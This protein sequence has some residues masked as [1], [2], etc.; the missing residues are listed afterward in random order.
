MK[1]RDLE[2]HAERLARQELAAEREAA[3]RR[4]PRGRFALAAIALSAVLFV[5][6][7]LTP[8]AEEPATPEPPL[9]AWKHVR[10]TG[11]FIRAFAHTGS[12]AIAVG[13][14]GA[15]LVSDEALET[16]DRLELVIPEDAGPYANDPLLAAGPVRE[17]LS[18]IAVLGGGVC[19]LVGGLEDSPSSTIIRTSDGGKTWS[20][21]FGGEM[22]W[23]QALR[24]DEAFGCAVGALGAC[25]TTS[26]GGA[27]WTRRAT[28]T[29]ELLAAV[30]V[31][32]GG[33]IWAVGDGGI[34]LRSG[35]YGATW[36]ERRIGAEDLAAIAF[37]DDLRGWA[38]GAGG[39][40]YATSDG[41]ATWTRETCD[42]AGFTAAR[43]DLRALTVV[44]RGA[45]FLL[46]AAGTAGTTLV[47][48]EASPWRYR[49]IPE[50]RGTLASLSYGNGRVWAS[51]DS[52]NIYAAHWSALEE[53]AR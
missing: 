42:D 26:D 28:G 39:A 50:D 29:E 9:L 3:K 38:L 43:P 45:G 44:P 31:R 40:I 1:R 20:R 4:R 14:Q 46:V 15:F 19:V 22:G 17:N 51:S 21:P 35:D 7:T 11:Q 8:G 18:G 34:L 33:R 41:G 32:P 5:L 24:F 16:W 6:F 2:R 25:I 36:E 48:T 23:L 13:L 10:K 49:P 53:A 47:R 52:G 12:G 37:A 27:T 30:S